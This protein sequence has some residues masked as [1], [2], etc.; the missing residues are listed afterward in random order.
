MSSLLLPMVQ[1]S[2]QFRPPLSQKLATA[3]EAED[4]SRSTRSLRESLKLSHRIKETIFQALTRTVIKM[5]QEVSITV[6]LSIGQHPR[7]LR[8]KRTMGRS[9]S[10]PSRRGRS[11]S[12]WLVADISSS[13]IKIPRSLTSLICLGD[14]KGDP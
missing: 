11:R 7:Q 5:V 9:S 1:A 6:L 12:F 13:M 4:P 14:L 8:K 3:S 10:M 2:V